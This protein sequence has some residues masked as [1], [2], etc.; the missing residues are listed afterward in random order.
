MRIVHRQRWMVALLAATLVLAAAAKAGPLKRFR[1]KREEDK[2][3]ILSC[4]RTSA[5]T[6]YL[7]DTDGGYSPIRDT[8]N[9]DDDIDWLGLRFSTFE[10]PR[11]RLGVFKV[12]NK[13]R[14]AA[15]ERASK[16]EVPVAG[17]E[18]LLT[19]ALYNTQRFDIIERKRLDLVLGEQN[20]KGTFEPSPKALYEAGQ[21]M[22]IQY[23]IY[24]TVNEW[25]PER[26]ARKGGIK[27]FIGGKEEAEVAISFSLTDITNAQ[28]LVTT[29]E[30]A[31]IGEWSFDI[32]SPK[33]ATGETVNMTPINY[34]VQACVNK[35]VYKI[36][37]YLRDQR[38][39]GAVV[40][41]KGPDIFI[42]AGSNHGMKP[43]MLL[44]LFAR[45]G[46]IYD[47]GKLLG[48]DLRAIGS[49][50]VVSVQPGFS[51]ARVEEGAKGIKVRDRVELA[52]VPP[53]PPVPAHC[54]G[55]LPLASF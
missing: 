22:G 43:G 46:V 26:A 2:E 51:I 28:V 6:A 9:T 16:V 33:G 47:K 41:I 54:A 15:D 13:S 53:L 48:E 23:L 8:Q 34:A 20:R 29:V 7:A 42:N 11:I 52:T 30:R 10:G 50:K 18:E 31:K 24:G 36:A 17:I 25:V 19:A 12:E 55:M 45:K 3:K 32:A 40:E 27:G 39:K 38:W 49:L 44:T 4:I 14:E 35:A 1:E 5:W 37:V 21:V